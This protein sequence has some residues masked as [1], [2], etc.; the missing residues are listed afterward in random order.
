[1]MHLTKQQIITRTLMSSLL[2][3]NKHC[4]LIR[5]GPLLTYPAQSNELYHQNPLNLLQSLNM[6]CAQIY[7][8]CWPPPLSS[9]RM[10]AI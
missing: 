8:A 3:Y 7:T 4:V 10:H 1:M 6:T 9:K 5:S 2:H